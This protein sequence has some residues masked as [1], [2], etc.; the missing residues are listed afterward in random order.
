MYPATNTNNGIKIM[1]AQLYFILY[2][3]WAYN[4][5]PIAITNHENEID[6]AAPGTP[7]FLIKKLFEINT[8]NNPNPLIRGLY[9][10][11][12]ENSI[13]VLNIK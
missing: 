12:L 8:D 9:L 2:N 5:L 6:N 11:D 10:G 1:I 4:K 7:N 3:F 13:P